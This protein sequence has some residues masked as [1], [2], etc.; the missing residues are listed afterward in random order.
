LIIIKRNRNRT[1]QDFGNQ[2]KIHGE[3]KDDHWTSLNMFKD[4]FPKDF[5]FTIFDQK[6]ILEVGSGSGRIL[7]MLS[8][9]DPK[10][11]IGVE[12][13]NGFELLSKNTS[14]LRNL[15]LINLS[16]SEFKVNNVDI[17]V[18]LGVIH[19]IPE[20][21]SVVQNVYNSLNKDGIF[22]MWVYGLENNLT[23]VLVRKT[24]SYLTRFLNDKFL[25]RISLALSYIFDLYGL[26][27]KSIFNNKLMLSSYYTQVFSR[28]G[29]QEK[30]YIIFDQLNPAYAK[31]YKKSEVLSLLNK[32]G[33]ENIALYHR[34]SYS[35]TA[36]ARK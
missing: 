24:L 4:H 18:S 29:R 6:N 20:P 15:K 16:G 22:V 23:Y 36:I 26:I 11:L 32:N 12:P 5:D 1:I 33:F 2:W 35:W 19:H 25:D 14:A 3:L 27:S 28:C 7:N 30:K 21:D 10:T 9:F 34:H 8:H 17:I 13:S 31:Y